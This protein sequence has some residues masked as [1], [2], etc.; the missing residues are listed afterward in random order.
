MKLEGKV[1]IITGAAGGLGRGIALCLAEEGADI[2]IADINMDSA[3]QVAEEVKAF[4]RKA[5]VVNADVTKEENARRLVKETLDALGKI[6]ILVNNVGAGHAEASVAGGNLTE[7]DWDRMYSRGITSLTEGDWDRSYMANLKP[8]ILMC[9]AVIPHMRA[10]KSG[11]IIN[12]SST[13]GRRGGALRLPY[14]AMKSAVIIL[15]QGVALQVARFNINVNCICP[16]IIYTS[17]HED[18]AKIRM[19]TNPKFKDAKNPREAFEGILGMIPM[20]RE[21]TP[22]DIGRCAVFLASEDARNITGQSI[23]V[24][25]G[26]IMS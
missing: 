16:G 22:E 19:R 26:S 25:G 11:K 6:D 15:T 5:L 2:V 13:A 23:N 8:G 10:Q 9:K 7:E 4:G 21:Q 20:G 24:D 3:N 17:I 12:I 1:A 14:S 18:M